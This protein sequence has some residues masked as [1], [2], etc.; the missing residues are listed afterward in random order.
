MK[1]SRRVL[2]G[3]AAVGAGVLASS[4]GVAKAPAAPLRYGPAP[5]IAKLNANENPF[6]PSEGAIKAM[7]EAASQ[8]AYYVGESVPRLKAMIAERHGLM[9]EHISLSSGSSGVLSFFA[10]AKGKEG[11]ILGPD[12]FW[13]TTAKAAERQGT[14]ILRLP[15]R[16]DLAIDLD[17]LYERIDDSVALVHVTNPNNPTGLTLDG[18]KLRA[19]CIKASKKATVLVD[20]AYNELTEDPEYT[21]MVPLVKA[22]HD[23]V[24]ARTFS[25]IY[26]L[27]GMRVGYMLSSPEHAESIRRY[28]LGDYALNQA[29]VAAAVASY[30]D[31]K[32]LALAKSR[33][34]AARQQIVEAVTEMGLKPL[35]SQTNFLFVDL[36][37][38]NAEA[39]RERMARENVLIRG[40]YRDYTNWSRVSM[41][42][43]AAVSQYVS[44][45][46][47]VVDSLYA[48]A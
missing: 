13:D 23:V 47:K 45:L 35:P 43:E 17:A 20:E 44:A 2:M 33:I 42:T 5:G 30:D 46:P 48:S 29:G 16:A 6:G 19:F 26:G 8:G 39:F 27:A 18:D 22:G 37:K 9:P 31:T 25:K 28:G 11:K 21:S 41:G 10:I 3:S 36:G 24:V 4:Q 7:A 34:E 12:L 32:F 15:K 38:M 14:E 1:L 40:I